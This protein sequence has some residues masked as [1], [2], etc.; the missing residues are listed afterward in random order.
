LDRALVTSIAISIALVAVS[1]AS[2]ILHNYIYWIGISKVFGSEAIYVFLCI[3]VYSLIDAELGALVICSVLLAVSTNVFLKVLVKSPRPPSYEQIVPAQGPGFPSGHS[4]VSSSFWTSL[5]VVR[6]RVWIAVLGYTIV[7]LV[8]ISRLVLR[9]HYLQDVVGGVGLGIVCGFLPTLIAMWRGRKLSIL[10][11]CILSI[12][13]ASLSLP[14]VGGYERLF[15]ASLLSI[16]ISM[17]FALSSRTIDRVSTVV[18]AMKLGQRIALFLALA[19]PSAIAIGVSR[20]WI[21]LIASGI[22]SG[23]WISLLPLAFSRYVLRRSS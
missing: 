10:I 6:R 12:L 14:M 22:F 8:A 21:E 18:K 3:L 7:A 17:G 2:S 15:R 20:S 19:I 23:V 9:V 1:T 11:S 5:A 13:F 16:G 4:E